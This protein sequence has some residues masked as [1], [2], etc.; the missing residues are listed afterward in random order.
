M[1]SISAVLIV[2]NEAN[3]LPE[4]LQSLSWV[5]E[6]IVL[7]S[8]SS[9]NTLE[10]AQGFSAKVF[11]NTDWQGFGVQR[12]RAAN[13]ATSDWIFMID[14]DE[15]VTPELESAIKAAISQG[16]AV[17]QINRLAWCF[18]RFI[19]HSGMHPDWIPR[20]YP[21]NKAKFDETRVHERLVNH[22]NLPVRRLDGV[23]LHYLFDSVRHQQQKA[24]HYAEE[25]ALQR[26]AAGK[27]TFLTS[28][29]LHALAC[30][31]RMYVFR[32]GFLDGKQG[33]L[34]ALLLSQST[35]SKYAELW[36]L[37]NNRNV[38]R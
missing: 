9:D 20:L 2:K 13:Y 28:A 6:I 1:P 16:D 17:W 26:A 23:L 33:F 14:A 24:A 27:K 29:V 30:F 10:I 11:T 7:D 22:L 38:K 37:T 4:C 15:R 5:N 31:L 19:K 21:R 18:G 32:L 34:L 12:E 8:G 35:F 36:Q 25:W 3:K